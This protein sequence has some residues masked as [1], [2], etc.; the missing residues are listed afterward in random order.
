MSKKDLGIALQAVSGLCK[1]K[2]KVLLDLKVICHL[3]SRN[4][5]IHQTCFLTQ[6]F[7]RNACL[8]I[9]VFSFQS[10]MSEYTN[11]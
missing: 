11:A 6:I 9:P 8:I 3:F 7:S 10:F 2:A 1:V 5:I 4:H